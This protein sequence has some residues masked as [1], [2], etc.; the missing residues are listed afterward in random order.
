MSVR[1]ETEITAFAD[2]MRAEMVAND[3]KGGWDKTTVP[4][5]L[6]DLLYHV[7]KLAV[8]VERD[9]K[10]AIHEYAADVGNC[11]MM[12]ADIAGALMLP[13]SDHPVLLS[14]LIDH[15]LMEA[16]TVSYGEVRDELVAAAV[17]FI[18]ASHDA[19]VPDPL[20]GVP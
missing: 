17:A 11:S 14:D 18:E 7:A 13:P 8:A 15:A 19:L 1:G 20:A 5:M 3:H 12:L 4:E 6:K 10:Q 2:S 9:H 16:G